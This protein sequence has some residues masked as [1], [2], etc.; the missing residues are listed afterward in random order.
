[1]TIDSVTVDGIEAAAS[2]TET[3]ARIDLPRPLVP[4]DSVVLR[5]RFAA[6]V[7]PQTDRFGHTG[8]SYSIGQWYPKVVVYDD[9]GWHLDPFH[10][11]AEFYGEYATYDV[12]IT[13]PDRHWVGATGTLQGV[14]GG[15]NDVPLFASG[16]PRDS[17]T[18]ALRVVLADSL[19]GRWPGRELVLETDLYPPRQRAP[20]RVPI[21]R[22]GPV[23]LRVPRAAPVHYGYLW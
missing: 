4:G 21:S 2:V 7:P 13:V 16:A 23:S 20:L 11:L 8:E 19:A 9:Q 22:G 3:I 12:A 5:M 1:M 17:V 14:E 6:Q 15:D 18:V 10:Y